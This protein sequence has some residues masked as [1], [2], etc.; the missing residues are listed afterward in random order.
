MI[1]IYPEQLGAQLREGLRACYLLNGN[2]PLLLQESQDAIRDAAQQH[3]FTEHFS[4]TL[5]ASTDWQAIFAI[6]QELNLFSSRQTLLLI[7]P[8]SGPNAAMSEQLL[9]LSGLLHQDILL[10]LRGGK[11]T[12]AQENSAWFKALSGQGLPFPV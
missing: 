12:K 4:A 10:I 8:E 1:R 11:L 7:L 6:C 3:G 5:D 9:T 2:E